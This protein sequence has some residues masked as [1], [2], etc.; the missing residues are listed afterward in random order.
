MS[1]RPSSWV[2]RDDLASDMRWGWR[3]VRPDFRS[4]NGYRWPFPGGWAEAPGPVLDH[5]GPCPEHV[6]DGLCV[7]L[8]WS[9]AALGGMSA[10]NPIL[11]VGWLPDDEL[12]RDNHKVRIRRGYV[13]DV[14]SAERI[15]MN[16]PGAYLGGADLTGADLTGAKGVPADV[17]ARLV[18]GRHP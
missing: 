15:L 12:G 9:G 14:W 5:T 18:N 11:V 4:R 3:T 10:R 2:D 17:A 6:G 13:A 7:A 8:D 1:D 16:A